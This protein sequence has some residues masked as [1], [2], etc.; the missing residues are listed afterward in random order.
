M[1]THKATRILGE[2]WGEMKINKLK[3]SIQLQCEV[4]VLG[5]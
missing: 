2:R 3:I 5:G 1:K 4:R